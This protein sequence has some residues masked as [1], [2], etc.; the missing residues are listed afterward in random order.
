MARIT[1]RNDPVRLLWRRMLIVVLAVL[2]VVGVFGVARAFREQQESA[3]L[4]ADAEAQLQ[5][6]QTRQAQLDG[7]ISGLESERGQ[8]AALRE[9][10]AL[11]GKGEGM[12]I[13]VDAA[14]STGQAAT[15][16]SFVDWLH[17]TFPWW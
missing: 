17:K 2:I 10:Y 7:D 11:A 6:L 8:E 12:I 15:S 16:S 4:R 3:S 14:T 1:Q 13:I 5:D 9:Q